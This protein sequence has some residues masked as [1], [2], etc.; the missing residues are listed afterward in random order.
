ML[1]IL[2]HFTSGVKTLD[3]LLVLLFS[4]RP[5]VCSNI[6]LMISDD[7]Q[8]RFIKGMFY[9]FSVYIISSHANNLINNPLRLRL[10][11][12][13]SFLTFQIYYF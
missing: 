1:T 6:Q 11:K 3:V 10:R 8:K 9:I 2:K 7:F 12:T 13:T 5:P 4:T